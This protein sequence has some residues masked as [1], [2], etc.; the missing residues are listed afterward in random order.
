[1]CVCLSNWYLAEL[2]GDK[3]AAR[4]VDNLDRIEKLDR[5][6][7]RVGRRSRGERL[8][9]L[10]LLGVALAQGGRQHERGREEEGLAAVGDFGGFGRIKVGREGGPCERKGVG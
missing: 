4:E 2:L 3:S 6:H 10:D 1:M 8:V 9:R 7:Q 5:A